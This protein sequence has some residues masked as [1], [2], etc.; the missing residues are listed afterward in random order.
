[1]TVF[2]LFTVSLLQMN[3]IGI[4]WL[5]A[6]VSIG[7]ELIPLLL[8]LILIS[9]VVIIIWTIVIQLIYNYYMGKFMLTLSL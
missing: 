3:I 4:D 9:V 8:M 7:T 6:V 5:E 1:M 2:D